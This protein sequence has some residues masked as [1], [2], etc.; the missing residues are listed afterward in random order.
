MYMISFP[1]VPLILAAATHV[2]LSCAGM[3]NEDRI[4]ISIVILLVSVF[5]YMAVYGFIAMV[6]V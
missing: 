4:P 1:M 5:V 6:G 2:F 3:N